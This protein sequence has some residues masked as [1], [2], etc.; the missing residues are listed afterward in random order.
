VCWTRKEGGANGDETY[1]SHRAANAI[2]WSAPEDIGGG[3][4]AQDHATLAL[5]SAAKRRIVYHDSTTGLG[6]NAHEIRL[7]TYRSGAWWDYTS[8]LLPDE[9]PVPQLGRQD[10]PF[11]ALDSA[12]KIHV[13]WE[14]GPLGGQVI[15]YTR[16][17]NATANG[18]D[19]DAEWEFNNV[20][21]SDAG[22]LN[23]H[24]PHMAIS[25][26]RTWVSYQQ[27]LPSGLDEVVLLHRCLGTP[28]GE[29][30]LVSDPYPADDLDESTE[31]YGTPHVA[32]RTLGFNALI[33]TQV[34]VVTRREVTAGAGRYEA[35]LYTSTEPACN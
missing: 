3:S 31:E 6:A 20:G 24:F 4:G 23:A 26:E 27:A 17:V 33:P 16:C 34:G 7:R 19:Q 9:L 28:N 1:C 13:A 2:G 10:R 29:A 32:T 22:A 35:V 11:V 8:Y 30:W 12:G 25:S 21:I 5:S 14:D 15:K 18:C